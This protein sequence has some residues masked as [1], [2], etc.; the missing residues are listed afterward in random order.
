MLN[1]LIQ[2]N[3]NEWYRYTVKAKSL[4]TPQLRTF[5]DKNE[6]KKYHPEMIRKLQKT[7]ERKVYIQR[8]M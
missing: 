6:Y 7:C 5:E 4:H 8:C 1:Y 3:C 2:L